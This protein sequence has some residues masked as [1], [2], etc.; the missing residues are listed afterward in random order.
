[1]SQG[2]DWTFHGFAGEFGQSHWRR[3]CHFSCG[4]GGSQLQLHSSRYGFYRHSRLTVPAAH[5]FRFKPERPER[6]G[7]YRK[8]SPENQKHE[9]NLKILFQ[10]TPPCYG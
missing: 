5:T 2:H 4:S 10:N 7:G 6:F 8:I 3:N 1:M 9:K